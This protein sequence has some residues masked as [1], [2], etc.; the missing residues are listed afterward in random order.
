[1]RPALESSSGLGA[2]VAVGSQSSQARAVRRYTEFEE[3]NFTRLVMRKKDARRRAREEQQLALG[4]DVGA[5]GS[6]RSRVGGL[7]GEFVGL[8]NSETRRES[9]DGYEELR[10]RGKKEA[11]LERSRVRSRDDVEFEG[12]ESGNKRKRGRFEKES[13]IAK[14]TLKKKRTS[15]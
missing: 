15:N 13:K 8:W 4:G 10:K 14:K 9:G 7:E 12:V 3:E 11:V 6:G 1:V 5:I 2:S